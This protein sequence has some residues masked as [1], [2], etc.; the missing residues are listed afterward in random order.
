MKR[1]TVYSVVAGAIV[2]TMGIIALPW[3]QQRS[4]QREIAHYLQE[5]QAPVPAHSVLVRRA[6]LLPEK[7]TTTVLVSNADAI[8]RG[9]VSG[10]EPA[11]KDAHGIAHH[12]VIMKPTSFLKKGG[13][14]VSETEDIRVG[15]YG[16]LVGEEFYQAE[17]APVFQVGED[18]VVYLQKGSEGYFVAFE[19]F[20]K[21]NIANDRIKGISED[22]G[23]IDEPYSVYSK[24]IVEMTSNY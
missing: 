15:V 20:G 5:T 6:A 2:I 8:V 21:L 19:A 16:G 9:T 24:R 23:L 4:N 11:S 13:S 12:T 7:P 10:I 22:R 3:M 1:T 14:I 18:V 17:D